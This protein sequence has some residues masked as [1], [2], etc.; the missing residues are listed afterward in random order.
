MTADI[1]TRRGGKILALVGSFLTALREPV[2]V[3]AGEQRST[4]PAST[5]RLSRSGQTLLGTAVLLLSIVLYGYT[6]VTSQRLNQRFQVCP[7]LHLE[8][9]SH[10]TGVQTSEKL[11]NKLTSATPG[12]KLRLQQQ[13]QH[14][15]VQSARICGLASLYRSEEVA[16]MTTASVALCLLCLSLTIGFSRGLANNTNR[17]WNTLQVTS[18]LALL[19]PMA[20]LQL[21]EQ[22]RYTSFYQQLYIDRRNLYEQMMSI[23]ANQDLPVWKSFSCEVNQ[24]PLRV[25]PGLTDPSKVALFI[26]RID[27][28]SQALPHIPLNLND[29]TERQAVGFLN[30]L[31]G[32]DS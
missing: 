6:F 22:K 16:L 9:W 18:A 30:A 29:A 2:P 32:G 21:G 7:H 12:Q 3:A 20:L 27:R 14:L 19:M 13:S 31:I 4:C 26:S 5:H 10:T 17:T 1:R 8:K 25:M 15:L 28:Q 24:S 11:I 23:M